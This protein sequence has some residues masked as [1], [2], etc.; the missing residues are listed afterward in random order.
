MKEGRIQRR[1]YVPGLFLFLTLALLSLS[2]FSVVNAQSSV[3]ETDSS[4]NGEAEAVLDETGDVTEEES[5]LVALDE[6]EEKEDKG[7]DQSSGE[8][9]SVAEEAA[10]S[11]EAVREA[12]AKATAEATAAAHKAD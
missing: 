4:S 11:E 1:R 12:E 7:L 8:S 6:K 2:K 3:E 10:A 5:K 9:D